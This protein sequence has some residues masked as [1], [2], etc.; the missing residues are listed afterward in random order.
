MC[1][2]RSVPASLADVEVRWWLGSMLP[3]GRRAFSERRGWWEQ[4]PRSC[5][6]TVTSGRCAGEDDRLRPTSTARL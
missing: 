6:G 2:L 5:G 3:W 4:I 1:S